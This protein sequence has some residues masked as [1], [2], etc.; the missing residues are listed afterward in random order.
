MSSTTPVYNPPPVTRAPQGQPVTPAPH[1]GQQ[2]TPHQGH[3]MTPSG[4]PAASSSGGGDLLSR[5]SVTSDQV[6]INGDKSMFTLSPGRFAAVSKYRGR[7]LIHVRDYVIDALSGKMYAT[8]RGV[9]MKVDEWENLKSN[10][11]AIDAAIS[12]HLQEK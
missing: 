7:V 10:M 6:A 2:M 3:P 9:A 1:Q 5:V 12:M 11:Y 8:K 4:Q